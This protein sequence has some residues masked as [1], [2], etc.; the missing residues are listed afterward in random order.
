MEPRPIAQ[1][2]VEVT[3]T[4]NPAARWWTAQMIPTYSTPMGLSL[5]YCWNNT[6]T[7]TLSMKTFWISVPYIR[8]D[9]LKKVKVLIYRF[10]GIRRKRIHPR[11]G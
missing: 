10:S 3:K 11:S 1:T 9:F 7:E 4:K 8:F 6:D 2:A 5:R